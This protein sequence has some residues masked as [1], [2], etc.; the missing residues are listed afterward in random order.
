[1]STVLFSHRIDAELKSELEKIAKFEDR[2]ASYLAN[3]AI[4]TLVEERQ[5][6]RDLLD[7]GVKMVET[8]APSIAAEDVHAWLLADEDAPFP[9][10]RAMSS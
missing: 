7:I 5:A 9:D 6:T 3:L 4:K 8:G 1:M 10:A 2:S